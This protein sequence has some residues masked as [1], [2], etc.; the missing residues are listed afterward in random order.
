MRY[1]LTLGTRIW[2]HSPSR[3]I[4]VEPQA[5]SR[6]DVRWSLD[7]VS[8]DRDADRDET[9]PQFTGAILGVRQW[10]VPDSLDELKPLRTIKASSPSWEID[11]SVTQAR[12][13]SDVSELHEPPGKDCECGLRAY[14]PWLVPPWY[15]WS[16]DKAANQD[17]Y[18]TGVVEAWGRIELYPEGFRAEFARPVALVLPPA[19]SADSTARIA[20]G[21]LCDH[22]DAELLDPDRGVSPDERPL[23]P[24][25]AAAEQR[26]T[27]SVLDDWFERN[28]SSTHQKVLEPLSPPEAKATER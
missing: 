23:Q 20:L 6:R 7:P 10:L 5:S 25:G 24:R 4:L 14:H 28:R 9:T 19:F 18:V 17:L 2:A 21:D 15:L 8:E 27:R 12:C 16:G 3:T 13:L 26:L 1:P 11:G 22:A